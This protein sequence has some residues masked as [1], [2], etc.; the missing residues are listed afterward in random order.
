VHPV[1]AVRAIVMHFFVGNGRWRR[2]DG[3]VIG[4]HATPFDRIGAPVRTVPPLDNSL[5][6]FECTPFS[7]HGFIG[8]HTTPRNVITLWV[9]RS[10]ADAVALWGEASVVEWSR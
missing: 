5:L 4:L 7:L 1:K 2:G 10:Y 3:G 8:G 6:V 9:H